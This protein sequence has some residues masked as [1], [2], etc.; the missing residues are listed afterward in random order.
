MVAGVPGHGGATWAVLQYVR[1]LRRLG[2]DVVLVEPVKELTPA[3]RAYFAEVVAQF[4]LD[5]RAALVVEATGESIGLPYRRILDAARVADLVI[6]INGML[7]HPD[8]VERA[9]VRLYLD[10]D[11]VFNQLWAEDGIDVGLARHTHFVT[12]GLG[13][14][15]PGSTLP[16]A[17]R[18]WLA[19]PQ[20]VVL[21]DWPVAG[22]AV[23]EGLTTVGNWRSYGSIERDGVRY[24]QK[25][26]SY[27]RFFELPT[28]LPLP[29]YAGLAIHPDERN[30]LDALAEN[31]WHLVD[32]GEVAGTPARYR[33]FVRGS[34]AEL[35]IAKEGYVVS[36]SRL[37]RRQER[38][39]P[40]LRPTGAG[41]GN[42]IQRL[43]SGRR[44]ADPV[45]DDRRRR[46]GRRRPAA[47]LRAAP[48][49]RAGARRGRVR[50]RQGARRAPQW[51]RRC[52]VEILERRPYAY[53]TSFPLD[54]ARIR[55]PDGD[56]AIVLVKEL[57]RSGLDDAIQRAK[58]EFVYDPRREIAVYEKILT[59][60]DLGT[61]RCYG[62]VVA[63]ESGRYVLFL[64]KVD[65][66]ELWQLEEIE[67]W[68]RAARWAARL[69]RK[70]SPEPK[71]PL[72]RY[73]GAYFRPWLERARS[74]HPGRTVAAL[75]SAHERALA[76]LAGLPAVFVHGEFYAS[77]ILVSEGRVCPVDWEMA[78]IGPGVLDLAALA[79]AWEGADG[80]RIVAAYAD[81]R[82]ASVDEEDLDAARLVLAVQ[83]LGWAEGWAPPREHA[84]DWLA[85]ATAAARR[86]R[87]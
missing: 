8:L 34:W 27:R 59:G 22:P 24:G 19:T 78:G 87:A 80:A 61:A 16:S 82:G 44:G 64:E 39:L 81:E 52:V 5:G 43:P 74:F 68:E 51:D 18:S 65:A 54:E 53:R 48:A 32:P 75:A 49:R 83:W 15:A 10:L 60:L 6:N 79:T 71:T 66:A 37:V 4:E 72:L 3:S 56:E 1:G 47:R 26:H 38:L 73:D 46:R 76:R 63:P 69:H 35:G 77:N 20:P 28:R 40:R 50:L 70:A 23:W 41:A 11:P 30:D 12:V 25:A 86:F 14:G 57:G 29:V 2:H 42:G 21:A 55:L 9:P 17:G 45:R 67:A 85:E 33:E 36:N 58:P 7:R 13:V 62:S 84:T 31:G